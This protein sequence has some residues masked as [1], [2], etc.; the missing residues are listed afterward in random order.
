MQIKF[1]A[2]LLGNNFKFIQLIWESLNIMDCFAL[3]KYQAEKINK[4]NMLHI[5]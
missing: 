5:R 4:Q 2:F 3:L 1:L